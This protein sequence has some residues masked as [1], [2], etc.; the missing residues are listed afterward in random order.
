MCCGGWIGATGDR[1]YGKITRRPMAIGAAG[2]ANLRIDQ[3]GL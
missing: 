3:G 2:L 1:P